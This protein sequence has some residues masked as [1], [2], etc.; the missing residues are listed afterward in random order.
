M[1]LSPT[2]M[3]LDTIL[4]L[5]R[6]KSSTKN[7]Q[8]IIESALL[9]NFNTI[10]LRKG[11]YNLSRGITKQLKMKYLHAPNKPKTIY[12]L[13]NSKTFSNIFEFCLL[14]VLM[15]TSCCDVAADNRFTLHYTQLYRM[16]SMQEDTNIYNSFLIISSK[17]QTGEGGEV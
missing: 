7:T 12:S 13:Q 8:K 4:I 1:P 6:P 15:T 11:F 10:K 2:E 16:D 5:K 9:V 17:H 3:E 14:S